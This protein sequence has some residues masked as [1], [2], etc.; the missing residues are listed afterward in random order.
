MAACVD[1]HVD[2]VQLLI[3]NNADITMVDKD[4]HTAEALATIN[5][6]TMY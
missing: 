6:N 5:D 4:G 1:G 3:E 2:I